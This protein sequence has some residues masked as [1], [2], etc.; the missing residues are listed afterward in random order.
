[1]KKPIKSIMC[2]LLSAV[3]LTGCASG[4]ATGAQTDRA[5]INIVDAGGTA[6][7]DASSDMSDK[8]GISGISQ[9][10][11]QTLPDESRDTAEADPT[12]ETASDE[13]FEIVIPYTEEADPD[14]EDTVYPEDVASPEDTVSPEDVADESEEIE[15][16]KPTE[17]I[18]DETD[19][20]EDVA[21]PEDV[22]DE[23]DPVTPPPVDYGKN[24]YNALNHAEVQG[25]WISYL[26]L[27]TLL[28]GQ[29]E[30]A[31][32]ANIGAAL[33]NCKNAGLNTVYIHA[34]SHSDAYYSSQ[35]FPWSKYVTGSIG[36]DPGFDPLEIVIQ[37]AHAR[38]I[39]VHAWINPLRAYSTSDM[40]S[41]GSYPAAEWLNGGTRLV[42]VGGYYYLNPAYDEV[43]RLI[44]DG[45][46]EIVSNYDV[47]GLH[48][49]DYFYPTTDA[50]F[51]STAFSQSGRSDLAAFRFDNCDRLVSAIYDAV[52]AANP[53]ALFSVSCQGSIENNYNLMYADV[54]KWCA[55][56][57]YLDY[58]VPQI[59][60]GFRN[61]TQPYSQCLSRWEQL[62]AAGG[63]PLVVGLSVSK[64]GYED[65][66][67]G[68]GKTEW[69]TDSAILARQLQEAMEC[70]SYGGAALYS[71]RSIFLPDSAVKAQVDSEM[72]EYINIIK[73]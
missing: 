36:A 51:D 13:P 5:Q 52:K 49:D 46:R 10:D 7:P 58:I 14:T 61:S 44:A 50:S 43:I 62:A 54:E 71:Y 25:V 60:Y 48:I 59:Y 26:E 12:E 57:G 64:I 15:D 53:T 19:D 23:N 3:L 30:S 40:G 16:V 24:S 56:S 67:A 2:L 6:A 70:G 73:R 66:W 47:D 11:V 28:K 33:D 37:Q 21:S 4:A 42:E 45:A 38:G 34:R 55:E 35:L 20:T 17:E 27:S 31:F 22:T 8:T 18:A 41:Y 63:K 65:T 9:P 29:S 72:A 68:D 1:M 32:T 69:L 39:S